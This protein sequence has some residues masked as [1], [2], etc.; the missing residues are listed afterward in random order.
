MA[1]QFHRLRDWALLLIPNVL[2]LL[3]CCLALMCS[4]PGLEALALRADLVCATRP[5][6][7]VPRLLPRAASGRPIG[8]GDYR[9]LR[10]KEGNK[11]STGH[12]RQ[13]QQQ[14]HAK[15]KQEE[16]DRQQERREELQMYS[17]Q[18]TGCAKNATAA[19]AREASDMLSNV[20]VSN[21]S[22]GLLMLTDLP[23]LS[24]LTSECL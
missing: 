4:L 21:K 2:H 10:D 9:S 17:S 11:D 7:S 1:S 19:A 13:R 15:H 14:V 23:V 16:Q 12:P 8:G 22:C 18:R 5:Q 20:F 24:L 6:N 3:Y